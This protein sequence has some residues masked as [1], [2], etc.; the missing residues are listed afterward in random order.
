MSSILEFRAGVDCE[1]PLANSATA[2]DYHGLEQMCLD[3][4]LG[5]VTGVV[6]RPGTAGLRPLSRTVVDASF[7]ARSSNRTARRETMR[8][9]SY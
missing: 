7:F 1:T 6:E 3:V 9:E 5:I 4:L 8:R 2:V